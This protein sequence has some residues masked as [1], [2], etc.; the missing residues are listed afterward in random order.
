MS[1]EREQVGVLRQRLEEA[2]RTIQIVFGP[3]QSGKTTIVTQALRTLTK[4]WRYYGV[5]SA[6]NDMTSSGLQQGTG[7]QRAPAVPRDKDWLIDVWRRARAD[8][9]GHTGSVLALDELQYIPDWSST[10]KGL[11]DG[12]RLND[13]PLHV[14]ILGSAPVSIQSSLNESLTGRFELIRVGHWSLTEMTT[15][16][17]LNLQQYIYFGGYPGAARLAD[18]WPPNWREYEPRWREYVRTSFIGPA[19]ERDVL[20]MTR[21]DKPALLG[22]LFELG[23]AYSGQILPLHKMLGQLQD[24]GNATTLARY[25]DLL[26]QVGLLTGLPKYSPSRLRQRASPPKFNVLNTALMT[27]GSDRSFEDAR[28]DRRFW[29]RLVE[30]AVGAHLLNTGGS[31]VRVHYWRER[32]DEVDFVIQQGLRTAAVEVK[33]GPRVRPTSGMKV[34]AERYRPYR[35]LL[36]TE[37]GEPHGSIPLEVFL[38]RPASAWLRNEF[39]Q[40][41]CTE[42]TDEREPDHEGA[43][44]LLS[45]YDSTPA[46]VLLGDAGMGKTTCFRELCRKLGDQAH[47][48]PARD[49]VTLDV[50]RHPEWRGKILFIDG[51]DEVRAGSDDARTALDRVRNRLDRLGNPRFR[52]SCREADWLGRNDREHLEK[53]A[54][55]GELAVLRLD[56]LTEVDVVEV[57]ESRF[58][59]EDGRSFLKAA[60]EAGLGDLLLNPQNLE[61]L[62]AGTRTGD[63]PEDRRELFEFACARLAGEHNEEHAIARRD[64]AITEPLLE[65]AG[66]LCSLLL[67]SGRAGVRPFPG[68]GASRDWP[69]L[70]HL[71]PPPNGSSPSETAAWS[72]QQRAALSSRLFRTPIGCPPSER[73]LEP[74]HRHIAEFLAARYL[75]QQISAGLPAARVISMLAAGD[76]R[77]V[78]TQRGLS[79]WLAVHSK[80]ARPGLIERDPIGVGLYGDIAG[81]SAGEK[82]SLLQALVPE[83]G[84]LDDIGYQNAAAFAPLASP[85]LEAEFRQL[86]ETMPRRDDDQLSVDFVLRLLRHGAPMPTLEDPI[87]A[88]FYRGEWWPRVVYAALDAFVRHCEDRETR[89][90]TLKQVLA[91]VQSG[92]V[93]DPDNQLAATV[94]DELYPD[95]IGPSEVWGHLN[96][97]RPTR[98]IGRHRVFWTQTL[99]ARTSN[100]GLAVLLDGLANERPDLRLVHPRL[101]HGRALAER[102]L[103]RGLAVHGA[104][105]TP[106]QLQDWLGATVRTHEDLEETWESTSG[107]RSWL[108]EHPD[109]YKAALLDCL[110]GYNDKQDLRE[111]CVLA[112]GR[113]RNAQPPPDYGIWCLNQAQNLAERRPELARWLFY[114]AAVRLKQGERGLS[115]ALL[116]E[117]AKEHSEWQPALRQSEDANELR[118]ATREHKPA[119]D[120]HL[121]R[122]RQQDEEW[123]E[124]V[125]AEL[126]AMR[127]NRAA[128]WLLYHLAGEWFQPTSWRTPSLAGWLREKFAAE[129]ELATA[130]YESFRGVIDRED[131]P[132]AAEILR[133]H[134][135]SRMHYLS[136]PLLASLEE[137]DRHDVGW[138]EDLSEDRQ[139]QALAIHYCT[140]T[141]RETAPDWCR[142]LIALKP[143]LA[144]SLLLPFVRT[145][146]RRGREH[147]PI[148]SDLAHSPGHA[149]L[150]RIASLPLLRGFPVRS[151]V[152]QLPNLIRLLWAALQHADR[153][154]L[155]GVIE[156][157]LAGK[158]MTV[159]QRVHWLAA[160]VIA[161]PESYA[162]RIADFIGAKELRARQ[163]A[164]FLWSEHP[165]VFRPNDLPPSALEVLIRQLGIA[166][167][168]YHLVD[169]PMDSAQTALLRLPGLIEPLAAS[170][171]PEAGAALH[172]LAD[173]ETLHR[174]RH[175]LRQARDRQATIS[176]DNSYRRPELDQVRATLDNLSP[177]NAADLAALSLDRLDELATTIRHANTND[178]S[179]Y[180]NQDGHGNPTTSKAENDCRNNLLSHLRS[181]LP[182]GV[183]AQPEGRYAASRRADIRLSCSGFHVPIEIKKNSHPALWR[184]ARDQ[185]VAKYT[186]DPAT[187]GYGIFLVLWFGEPEKTPLDET[188]TRPA[189]PE[190]LRQR[191]EACI[192]RQLPPEQAR[193][194]AVRV[195]DVSKP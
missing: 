177:A 53:V 108:E 165:A 13:R 54:P 119:G 168:M 28:A 23:A 78:T 7:P 97:C 142:R 164:D 27:V 146:L 48:I 24:A 128:P 129:E 47:F 163:L 100:E 75:A 186:Q 105:L 80:P 106:Q 138:G 29:G 172:R 152:G 135:E 103:A 147:V 115:Q 61:L 39:V 151:H 162:D 66:R 131:L 113:L 1:Y 21:V 117:C 180:W 194:I 137:R 157:K 12:D 43:G 116:D 122:R 192:T 136:L 5:D 125:R 30:S 9:E 87:L 49:F 32:D 191:L 59:L 37:T 41:S 160:G 76:G 134:G 26:S 86:L 17:G 46:Y 3:R 178:W 183:D 96:R 65:A 82:R 139:R 92:K 45:E 63:W 77:V 158:S 107:V 85:A 71:D 193:K 57:A 91:D 14:V 123:L 79:A 19:I 167:G 190:E 50:K 56:P 88:I 189:S 52:L 11:W 101:P 154:E 176:R 60:K 16:F 141:G 175:H 31:G 98:L 8:A 187:G 155:L 95:V 62:I 74:V 185:L 126:P 83:G 184:A 118:E 104:R 89:N 174:W 68:S 110:S 81:F 114:L 55:G 121:E 124:A 67:L 112:Q 120:A 15:A 111:R 73:R 58:Y 51:L 170:P 143:E 25:L 127:N 145:E 36:V 130:A 2:P 149:D 94:L 132:S 181:L 22:R 171:E 38:S 4:P 161:A 159:N 153:D 42:I 148:L 44:K 10:V 18:R 70:E 35:T 169:G 20:A 69:L 156:K 93:P 166:F 40:R 173:D 182:D 133:L 99:E 195:I 188:G 84:R 179:Q 33:T 90:A 64:R 109:A 144:E 150:A 140:P 102:L 34:F 6:D 72:S